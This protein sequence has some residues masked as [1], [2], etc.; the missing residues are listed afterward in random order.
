MP[1]SVS[2]WITS[3]AAPVI[4]CGSCLYAGVS[5][6]WGRRNRSR[7]VRPSGVPSV[8]APA[9]ELVAR[10]EREQQAAAHAQRIVREEFERIGSLYDEP[11][12]R[13]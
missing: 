3:L 4:L 2:D 9:R 8:F 11:T 12:I 1:A 10:V 13:L 5:H 6:W 7:G